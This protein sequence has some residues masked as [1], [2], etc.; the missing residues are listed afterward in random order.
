MATLFEN[1]WYQMGNNWYHINSSGKNIYPTNG[2][3]PMASGML[4]DGY[5][6]MLAN[7]WKGDY[8]LKSSGAMADKEWGLRKATLVGFT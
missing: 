2:A 4:F 5:G 3:K 6:R 1:S 8:Y 7:I